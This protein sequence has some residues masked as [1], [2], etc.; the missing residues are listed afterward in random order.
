MRLKVKDYRIEDATSAEDRVGNTHNFYRSL[1]KAIPLRP[2]PVMIP[3][4]MRTTH[5]EFALAA[6]IRMQ[7]R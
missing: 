7:I 3:Q 2:E 6:R 5:A 4:K 1:M